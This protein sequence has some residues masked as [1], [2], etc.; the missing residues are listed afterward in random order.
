MFNH[1]DAALVLAHSSLNLVKHSLAVF[2]S[3][4]SAILIQRSLVG[5][6]AGTS[7]IP[8]SIYFCYSLVQPSPDCSAGL[9]AYYL[10]STY[11]LTFS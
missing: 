2:P 1:F 9:V 8:F 7:R 6:D 11:F 10:A 5:T 4:P 3:T